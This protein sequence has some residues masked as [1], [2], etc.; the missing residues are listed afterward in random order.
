MDSEA[1]KAPS[2]LK[3]TSLTGSI[4]LTWTANTESDLLG[5]MV[6]RYNERAAI[7]ETIGRQVREATFVDNI[8]AKG[9]AYRYRVRA[10]DQSWNLSSPSSE[11]TGTTSGE[12]ALL[13]QWSLGNDLRDG[14]ENLLHATS[15]GT[16]F[17][18]ND[19]H[20]G[21]TFDGSNAYIALP[22]HVADM[23]QMTFSA[24]VKPH[25]HSA[26]RCKALRFPMV[27]ESVK[28]AGDGKFMNYDIINLGEVKIPRGKSLETYT[29]S[30]MFPGKPRK[31]GIYVRK[32]TD[33]KKLISKLE[34]IR[35]N[36]TKCKVLVTSTSINDDV[37][38]QKFSGK[39]QGGHKDFF[40][41]ITLVQAVDIEIYTTFELGMK[42]KKKKK[43]PAPAEESEAADGAKDTTRQYTV[44][45]GDCLWAIA[46]K[47]LGNGARYKEIYELNKSTIDAHHGGPNM[48]WPGDHLKI[49]AK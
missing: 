3:A 19:T 26:M 46:Q 8:C 24:W 11:T 16:G 41:E 37:Y 20:S 14:S 21:A 15:T 4:R 43:R 12:H 31:K 13:G 10:V 2:G 44:K 48:I 1:P 34:D 42:K 39:F 33:P 5:Y 36:G 6:Y 45:S 17:A 9:Q 29:W 18:E 40:Y 23:Q 32:W 35:D 22:Y 38:I 25:F 7:W 47:Y 49:P 27:P 30:G 28:I